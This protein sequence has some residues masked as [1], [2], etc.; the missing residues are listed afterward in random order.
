MARFGTAVEL[1]WP[2]TNVHPQHD[3]STT[4]GR[5]VTGGMRS[6]T[7]VWTAI[8]FVP[9]ILG[10]FVIP[11][12]IVKRS[13]IDPPAAGSAD[14]VSNIEQIL[15]AVAGR[16][17]AFVGW[18]R[19]PGAFSAVLGLHGETKLITLRVFPETP[20]RRQNLTALSEYI[21]NVAA[22]LGDAAPKDVRVPP[23]ADEQKFGW[24]GGGAGMWW[25]ADRRSGS[26][27]R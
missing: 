22:A 7:V 26:A 20:T 23:P 5:P 9:V 14:G 24:V 4:T 17:I 3:G 1:S 13:V 6:E 25:R 11:R 10:V 2:I 15:D 12:Y 19:T 18:D 21:R 27:G 8:I 16:K